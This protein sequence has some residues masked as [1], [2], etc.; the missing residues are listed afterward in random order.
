MSFT[1][2]AA[3]H[4]SSRFL[5]AK[6]TTTKT[7]F[8]IHQ[9]SRRKANIVVFPESYIAAFP[10]WSALRPPTENH[11]FFKR[12]VQESIYADGQEI[13]AIRDTARE[14]KTVISIGISEKS[15]SSTACLYNSNLLINNDGEVLVHHRKLMPTFFEKLVWSSGDGHGLRVAETTYGNV[16]ALICGEN[17]NPLARYSLMA[18]R[19]QIHIS[20]WPAIWPT[21][22]PALPGN[23]DAKEPRNYDNVLA[24]QLRAAAHCFE[25]KAFGVSAVAFLIKRPLR[26]L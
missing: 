12:M 15:H 9:A 22:I 21:R 1:R 23:N 4:V 14:T 10:I 24:N 13:Q 7:I 26:R 6:E 25:A 5:S 11:T 2:V 20:S 3:C 18:Q 16:G 8:L 19:E 17:T